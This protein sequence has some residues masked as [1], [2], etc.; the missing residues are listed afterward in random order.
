MQHLPTYV[1]LLLISLL[2]AYTTQAQNHTISGYIKDKESGESLIGANVFNK[3]DLTGT[4]TNTYGFYSLTLPQDSVTLVVSYVGYSPIETRI[5]L[6]KD[7]TLNL[8]LTSSIELD[9]IVITS[10]EEIQQQTR[11]STI[12]VPVQQIKSLPALMGEVDVLKVMQLL[13][14]VQSGSEGS[15]GLYV[16]GGGPDQNLILLDGVPIYNSSHLF[17]FF[18]VFNADAINK[19]EL[20]KGGFPARYGGRLSSVIDISMKEGSTKEFKG[21]ATIGLIASKVTLEAPIKKDK[22]SF[23][24]SARRT[25]IDI[26]ARPIIKAQNDGLGTAGYYFYDLN[27]KIN[28]KFSD[29]DRLYVSGFFGQ[30]KAF[31]KFKDEYTNGNQTTQYQ[32]QFGLKWGN[33]IGALRWNHL[34][35]PKLFSNVTLTYSKYKFAVFEET[36]TKTITPT[37]TQN[38]VFAIEY[39]SGIEDWAAKIDFDFI[40]NPGHYI[41]FGANGISHSFN[42]GVLAYRL[43]D[44]DTVA[45]SFQTNALEFAAYIED[46]ARL[47]DRLK[48]N[49]GVHFSGFNVEGKTYTSIQPRV[50]ARYLIN[51]SLS[52]KASYAQ[53]AQFI[54]LL[55]NSG[56][57]LPTDL[58][59]PSTARIKPQ[60]SYQVAL[61]LAKTFSPMYELSI[62]GY[63][64]EMDNLIEYKDGASFTSVNKD[65]QDKV[66]SGSGTSYGAEVF[67]QKKTG[68]LTGWAGYTLSWTNRQFDNINFGNPYPYRYDRRHDI[69]ITSVYKLNEHIELAGTWVFGTGNSITLPTQSYKQHNSNPNDYYYNTIN[70]YE[71]RNSY[72]MPAYHRLDVSI[73]WVKQKKNGVRR[74]TLGFYNMYNR[75][76]P[77]FI[78][79]GYDNNGNKKFVQYSLMPILPSV[80]YRFDF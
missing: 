47:T 80:S 20:I 57:G 5:Y 70:Y 18:S 65:W 40:P 64:K 34:F 68:K 25:Y 77:F 26:L 49:A 32:D 45:G 35:T 58:W 41:R 37:D 28:H 19:V 79:T 36:K 21:T 60:T 4:T 9:E 74:F 10:E 3:Q 1:N 76:N 13:P 67:F 31:S 12:D 53:M 14:G 69:S 23:L 50:A 75:K 16:R 78:T 55:T 54:H 43:D 6:D 48:V 51:S 71:G 29:K 15:S 61:G 63:Y 33:A 66:E 2:F 39:N 24:F 56:I 52:L 46:D 27:A 73:A 30:D 7:I 11:M 17:G 72:R 44:L 38:E 62:E 59:V 22:T 8:E 42:P